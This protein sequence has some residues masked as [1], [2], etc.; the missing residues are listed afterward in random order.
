[1][2]GLSL[3]S[4]REPRL[5]VDPARSFDGGCTVEPATEDRLFSK[6]FPHDNE[7]DHFGQKLL[8]EEEICLLCPIFS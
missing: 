4:L 3:I 7:N 1:M 6:L 8:S 5:S 2:D